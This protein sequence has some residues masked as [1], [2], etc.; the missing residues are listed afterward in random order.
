MKKILLVLV[1]VL[2]AFLLV[3]A[4]LPKHVTVARSTTIAADRAKVHALCSD[5]TRWP[6]WS[7]WTK[8]DPS[9]VVKLGPVTSGVGASQTWTGKD[10]NGE[11]KLTKSDPE[12]GIAYDMAFVNGDHKSPAVSTMT[13]RPNGAATDV[14][15]T[16]EADMDI[17]IFGGYLVFLMK[18][19]VESAFDM[20][21]ADLKKRAEA[22]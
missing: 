8:I 10:G 12:S 14:T 1:L 22:P 7:P 15:W 6:E 21:L 20:G 9:V 3:G 19:S 13:Y 18:G 5:L 4:F 11:L 16:L 2:V 17:P